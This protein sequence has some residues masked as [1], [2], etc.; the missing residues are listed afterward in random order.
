MTEDS[1]VS[2]AEITASGAGV[3][4]LVPTHAHPETVAFSLRSVLAQQFPDFR[5]IVI[6]DGVDDRTRQMLQPFRSDARVQILDRPKAERNGERLRDA[7]IR[8]IDADVIAYHGDDDLMLPSH[9]DDMMALLETHDLVHPLPVRVGADDAIEYLPADIGDPQVIAWL[10]QPPWRNAISLTGVAHTR[11][12]Y[13]ALPHGWRPAPAD[14]WSD[15][16]MWQQYLTVPGLRAATSERSTTIKLQ[17]PHSSHRDWIEA[18]WLRMQE[19]GFT[20]WWDTAAADAVRAAAVARAAEQ[21]RVEDRLSSVTAENDRLNEQLTVSQAALQHAL[22]ESAALRQDQA[23]L[24][25]SR[26]WRLTTPLRALQRVPGRRRSG[27][28]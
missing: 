6:A 11:S 16:F 23:A 27:S 8:H 9:L 4:V 15:H 22:A 1:E 18:W 14:R 25:S 7:V 28:D 26:S 3:A 21:Y 20:D 24:L 5:V 12:S 17:G 10:T 2:A 13:L 19:P